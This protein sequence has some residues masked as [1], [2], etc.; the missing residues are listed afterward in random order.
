MYYK[1]YIPRLVWAIGVLVLG[2]M[3]FAMFRWITPDQVV[4]AFGYFELSPTIRTAV[5]TDA[6]W[7]LAQG[8]VAGLALGWAIAGFWLNGI[9]KLLGFLVLYLKNSLF[10]AK[11]ATKVLKQQWTELPITARSLLIALNVAIIIYLGYGMLALPLTFDEIY[12]YLTFSIRGPLIAATYYPV[13]NNHVLYNIISSLIVA[14]NVPDVVGMRLAAFCASVLTMLFLN[15]LLLR[16]TKSPWGISAGVLIYSSL[17]GVFMYSFLG[18]GYSFLFL[19]FIGSVGCVIELLSLNSSY[20]RLAWVGFIL[21][22]VAGIY[23]VPTY[24]YPVASQGLL[25][26]VINWRNNQSLMK[27][28]KGLICATTVIFISVL[29]LYIPVILFSSPHQLFNNRFVVPIKR[30]EVLRLIPGLTAEIGQLLFNSYLQTAVILLLAL[31][32]FFAALNGRIERRLI[33][34]AAFFILPIALIVLQA[35]LPPARVWVYLAVPMVLLASAGLVTV[36]NNISSALLKSLVLMPLL[37]LW[38]FSLFQMPKRF[39]NESDNYNSYVIAESYCKPNTTLVVDPG[40]AEFMLQYQ[41]HKHN[42]PF[43][44]LP[45]DSLEAKTAVGEVVVVHDKLHQEGIPSE[46]Y[47]PLTITGRN[48]KLIYEDK[49][50]R[51]TKWA[52]AESN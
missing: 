51:V 37:G 12:S 44:S 14:F 9:T 19:F 24:I 38:I 6:R 49:F 39:H 47:E 16:I 7:H 23:T 43:A 4:N 41:Y 29:A 11:E 36:T 33:N 26:S 8:L 25:L 45:F 50:V 34:V 1:S 30:S 5:L 13:P 48:R 35:V 31:V 42:R 27:R 52:P 10:E 22:S 18:R 3:A 32:G 20:R 21:F 17:Y 2:I 40:W 15:A 28:W 46:D